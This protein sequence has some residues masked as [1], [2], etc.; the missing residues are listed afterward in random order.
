MRSLLNDISFFIYSAF[1]AY[2]KKIALLG[3]HYDIYTFSFLD[4][5]ILI[6]R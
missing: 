6:Y 4:T 1:S 5:K 2:E 3:G